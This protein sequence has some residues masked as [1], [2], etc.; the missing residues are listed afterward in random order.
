MNTVWFA[1]RSNEKSALFWVKI[2]K[3]SG[4]SLKKIQNKFCPKTD[5]SIGK[6]REFS[7]ENISYMRKKAIFNDFLERL[8]ENRVLSLVEINRQF[9]KKFEKNFRSSSIQKLIQASES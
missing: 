3:N 2:N 1:A 5:S 8:N 7:I 6:R 4:I 9:R